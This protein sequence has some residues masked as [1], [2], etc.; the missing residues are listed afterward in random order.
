M[1]RKKSQ[2]MPPEGRRN[3]RG[4]RKERNIINKIE[5]AHL[6]HAFRLHEAVAHTQNMITKKSKIKSNNI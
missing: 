6:R 4:I 2:N 5:V 1:A 3:N